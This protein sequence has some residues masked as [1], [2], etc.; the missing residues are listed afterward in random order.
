MNK[1]SSKIRTKTLAYTDFPFL[2]KITLDYLDKHPDL[3]TFIRNFPSLESLIDYGRTKTF[4]AQK[5]AN[6]VQVL[7]Q[8]YSN[9]KPSEIREQQLNLLAKDTSFCVTTGHQ[10]SLLT[11]PLYFIYKIASIIH[12]SRQLNAAQNEFKAIPMFW[13]ASED[14]DFEEISEVDI[15]GKTYKWETKQKGAVGRMKV[16]ELRPL[17]EQIKCQFGLSLEAQQVTNWIDKAFKKQTL[18]EAML[19]LVDAIFEPYGLL[20]IEPDQAELKKEMQP[21]FKSELEHETS[22]KAFQGTIEHWPK[23]YKKQI[24]ARACNLFYLNE[25]HRGRLEKIDE[26]KWKVDDSDLEF[27]Q[28]ELLDILEKYPERFSPNVALRPLYQEVIL[29]NLA[30]IGG[31]GELSYWFLLKGIFEQFEVDFP[32]LILR[33]SNLQLTDKECNRIENQTLFD[34]KDLLIETSE[35]EERILKKTYQ[36]TPAIQKLKADLELSFEELK[37]VYPNQKAAFEHREKAISK[38]LERTEH[39]LYKDWKRNQKLNLEHYIKTKELVFPKQNFQERQSNF[40]EFYLALGQD[41]IEQLVEHSDVFQ[42][43]LH[44]NIRE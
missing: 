10:L 40:I 44:L 41:W 16:D 22:Y 13:M 24:N 12:L 19:Y 7:R 30:Y 18:S 37:A 17:L 32:Y 9:L 6:L 3:E 43:E 14:H 25:Q 15:F 26:N 11:G 38:H 1:Q 33:N 29:P 36:N 21:Y 5:R 34:W 42:Q 8:Q 28:T 35:F 4:S 39:L 23:A 27:S 31:G 20:I 2:S